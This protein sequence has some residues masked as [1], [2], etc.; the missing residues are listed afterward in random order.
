MKGL[1]WIWV[2]LSLL[3]AAPIVEAQSKAPATTEY[4]LGTGDV[5]RITVYQNPDLQ[6][7]TRVGD[8]GNLSFPLLGNVKVGGLSVS[9]AEQLIADGLRSGS[10]VKQPQV[11]MVVVQVR[12]H[13]ANVL[14]QVNRPGRYPLE[15]SSMRLTDL[16]SL[17]GGATSNASDVLVLTGTRDGKPFRTEVDLHSL[18]AE[19]NRSADIE[20]LNGDVLWLDRTPTVYIYGE[21]QRPGAMRLERGMRLMQ[22]LAAGGGL[23]QRGTERGIRLHRKDAT[24]KVQ[25]IQSSLDDALIDGDVVYVRESL[26]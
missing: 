10:F 14:G 19:A 1:R 5:V 25:I 17:A 8:G 18:F 16:L 20:V 23:T 6:S 21:V 26:F 24:G 11:T 4:R 3:I 12:A 15:M 7:E 9:A 2:A 22:A 13:V